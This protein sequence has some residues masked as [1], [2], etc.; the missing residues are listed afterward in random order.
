MTLHKTINSLT[1]S[2][3]LFSF[4]STSPRSLAFEQKTRAV[5]RVLYNSAT[6]RDDVLLL[7]LLFSQRVLAMHT[8]IATPTPSLCV[9][10]HTRTVSLR[11]AVWCPFFFLGAR[12]F[13]SLATICA[14][15]RE[16]FGGRRPAGIG[17]LVPGDQA[18][19][20]HEKQHI[21][22]R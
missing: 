16:L 2:C 21:H 12:L 20:K 5:K 4:F 9:C 1:L 18:R 6:N 3:L 22:R 8:H 13:C 15:L 19:R 10:A 7:L 14:Q 11:Y 17:Q